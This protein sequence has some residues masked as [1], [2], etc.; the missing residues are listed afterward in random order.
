MLSYV[1]KN[2]SQSAIKHIRVYIYIYVCVCVCVTTCIWRHTYT[3][4]YTKDHTCILIT[5]VNREKEQLMYH[6]SLLW[7]STDQVFVVCYSTTLLTVVVLHWSSLCCVLFLYHAHTH[8]SK[9]VRQL[10][11]VAL[12]QVTY[13]QHSTTHTVYVYSISNTGLDRIINAY[14]LSTLLN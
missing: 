7:Y 6:Y 8:T 5:R 9:Q 14:M 3:L 4:M 2:M 13:I 1:H 11:K 10:M 12:R